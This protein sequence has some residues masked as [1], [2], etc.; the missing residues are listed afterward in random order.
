MKDQLLTALNVVLVFNGASLN[1]GINRWASV[2]RLYN[3]IIHDAYISE[4]SFL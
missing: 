1:W 4:V 3:T 2:V